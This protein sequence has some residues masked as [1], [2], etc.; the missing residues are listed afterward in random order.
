MNF[1]NV[2]LMLLCLI[3]LAGI[4]CG[5][6]IDRLTPCE[7]T[8]Q[9]MEY[10]NRDF[11]PLGIMT[12]YEAK[13]IQERIIIKHRVSQL[14]VK[15]IAEDDKYA[16]DDAIGFIN[17]NIAAS[18]KFQGVVVGSATDPMSIMG[19]LGI[20]GLGLLGGRMQ[21]RKGDL[22]PAEVEEVV[23]KAKVAAVKGKA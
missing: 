23:A 6:F 2:A 18:Q 10:A 8:E 20:G 1:K 7:V 9:S 19:L 14:S 11:P 3:C 21:K 13:Q 16:H 12:L 15:R 17:D 5:G 22:A 4:S